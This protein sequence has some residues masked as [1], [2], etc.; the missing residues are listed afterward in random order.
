MVEMVDMAGTV[1][2]KEVGP[3]RA[4]RAVSKINLACTPSTSRGEEG[5]WTQFY[6]CD[7]Q[8]YAQNR[9]FTCV[10]DP[11]D[12]STG[13]M[14]AKKIPR[15]LWRLWCPRTG[16]TSTCRGE[17]ANSD[18]FHF[19][20][21]GE[22]IDETSTIT[23]GDSDEE[24]LDEIILPVAGASELEDLKPLEFFFIDS[25]AGVRAENSKDQI[26]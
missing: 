18:F 13:Y 8:S 2:R 21:M 10:A 19:N 14:P 20:P 7:Q 11:I 25:F 4:R 24:S 1:T 12:D 9:M 26:G 6:G 5:C 3:K 16:T 15:Q 17:A 23:G 22:D